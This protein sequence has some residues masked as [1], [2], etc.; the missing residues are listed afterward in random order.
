M[1]DRATCCLTRSSSAPSV[2]CEDLRFLKDLLRHILPRIDRALIE[3]QHLPPPEKG[4]AD[5][6]SIRVASRAPAQVVPLVSEDAG[7][8]GAA[9]GDAAQ[10]GSDVGSDAARTSPEMPRDPNQGG[11]VQ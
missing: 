8:V 5:E 11:G 2:R 3:D 7:M 9:R 1:F 6:K 4:D 10:G